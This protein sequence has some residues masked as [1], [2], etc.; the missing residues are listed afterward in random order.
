MLVSRSLQDV[1]LA[2]A[3]FDKRVQES[4]SPEVRQLHG[5]ITDS[6][7][8]VDERFLLASS[9]A[10]L[11]LWRIDP[12][13]IEWNRTYTRHLFVLAH[14][15]RWRWG[16]KL[17][18]GI[19]LVL[20]WFEAGRTSVAPN[21]GE[22]GAQPWAWWTQVL[23][24][25]AASGLLVDVCVSFGYQRLESLLESVR[26]AWGTL[27]RRRARQH[28]AGA[29]PPAV[30]VLFCA[31]ASLSLTAA[32]RPGVWVHR[33]QPLPQSTGALSGRGFIRGRGLLRGNRCNCAAS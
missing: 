32:L 10:K 17:S 3:D 24:G 31:I 15:R 20:I 22:L 12:G 28:A 11:A 1:G 5:H 23:E 18:L 14:D 6:D 21:S 19:F 2:Q 9:F 13:S 27:C 7:W 30:H 25:M 8:T 4:T 16:V 29:R 33:S 26:A